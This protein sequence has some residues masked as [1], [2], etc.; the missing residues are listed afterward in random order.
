M[1]LIRC[2]KEQTCEIGDATGL[3]HSDRL[4][5]GTIDSIS[6]CL[7][8]HSTNMRLGQNGSATLSHCTLGT[9]G[10]CFNYP[11]V[12]DVVENSASSGTTSSYSLKDLG[13]LQ[14]GHPS[15][16][17]CFARPSEESEAMR[18]WKAIKQNGFLSHPNGG[19]PMPEPQH[20]KRCKKRTKANDQRRR[21]EVTIRDQGDRKMETEKGEQR[22]ME[23]VRRGQDKR[24]MET[25]KAEPDNMLKN[26]PSS[27]L[28]STISTGIIRRVKNY[29]EVHAILEDMVRLEKPD[30]QI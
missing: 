7:E 21:M 22:K 2:G 17:A 14:L 5:Q 9:N 28:L 23:M 11:V 18:K 6:G 12:I 30:D 3:R 26:A 29:E 4:A 19:V 24:K 25:L 10:S 27:G 13:Q 16:N 20:G 1:A 15:K 8:H